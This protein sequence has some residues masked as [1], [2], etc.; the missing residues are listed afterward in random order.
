MRTLEL[1]LTSLLVLAVAQAASAQALYK[2]TDK[3]GKV[4][5][6]DKPPKPGEK[7]ELVKTDANVN[8]ISAPSNKVEGV[9]QSLQEVNAR[10][11]ARA[12]LREKLRADVDT[13]KATLEQ[14][15]KAL[16]D[17]REATPEERQI[18]VR[19]GGNAVLRKPEYYERIAVLE[20]AVK[21]AEE[22]LAKAQEKFDREA[23]G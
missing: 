15:K 16:E 22:N 3:D 11:A 10:A 7:A 6:S 21:Q 17:G 18:I 9:K 4:S 8:V 12:N 23:P 5:Y 14:A 13:A 20:A 2:Y 1:I 19:Q